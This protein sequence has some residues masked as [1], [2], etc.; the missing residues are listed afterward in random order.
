MPGKAEGIHSGPEKQ[1]EP[2][3][4]FVRPILNATGGKETGSDSEKARQPTLDV[5]NAG[6]QAA[7][8]TVWNSHNTPVSTAGLCNDVAQQSQQRTAAET[9]QAIPEPEAGRPDDATAPKP[10]ILE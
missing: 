2:N 8:E 4:T 6:Q 10:E 9:N 7:P 3:P 5:S 1:T